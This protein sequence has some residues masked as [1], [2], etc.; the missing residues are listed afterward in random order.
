MTSNQTANETNIKNDS[1]NRNSSDKLLHN[2]TFDQLLNEKSEKT[3]SLNQNS[4]DKLF[5][6]DSF[7]QSVSNNNGNA[8]SLNRRPSDGRFKNESY[9]QSPTNKSKNF[10]S[11]NR[12]SSDSREDDDLILDPEE[13]MKIG[14]VAELLGSSSAT[15]R[16]YCDQLEKKGYSITKQGKQRLFSSEDI[17]ILGKMLS[18]TED[19]HLNVENAAEMALK[20]DQ[21]IEERLREVRDSKDKN[22]VALQNFSLKLNDMFEMLSENFTTKEDMKQMVQLIVDQDN[23]K[24]EVIEMQTDMLLQ[25]KEERE[26]DRKEKEEMEK[27]LKRTM[28]LYEESQ[29]DNKKYREDNERHLEVAETVKEILEKLDK[30]KK[31]F[32]GIF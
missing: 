18:C 26:K 11:L 2:D 23:K 31:K 32:L 13:K 16:R 9:N 20:D 19:L 28:E 22:E 14:K 30:P 8:E 29:K 12:F 7:K 4:S 1:L 27:Q 24:N 21:S 25:L 17:E 5:R 3:E 6:N 15:L 10:E